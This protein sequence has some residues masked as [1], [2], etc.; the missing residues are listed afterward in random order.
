MMVEARKKGYP[1]SR[2][3]GMF[4]FSQTSVSGIQEKCECWKDIIETRKLQ[5]PPR[6]GL[7]DRYNYG[8]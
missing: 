1:I 8:N 3:A 6:T 7:Q 2:V 4:G 5:V